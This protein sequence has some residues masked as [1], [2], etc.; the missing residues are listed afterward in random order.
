MRPATVDSLGFK[1]KR[2]IL[3]QLGHLQAH[4]ITHQQLDMFVAFRRGQGVK[5]RTIRD[6]L[7]YIHAV[8]NF[9]V[10]RS[11]IVAN[12]AKGYHPPRD[13]TER[14]R[15]PNKAEFEAIVEKAAPHIQR[16]MWT[17]YFTGARP[18]PIELFSLQW[19]TVD[20]FRG[21]ITI[22]SAQKGGIQLRELNIPDRFM[23]LLRKWWEEDLATEKSTGKKPRFIIHHGG[24]QVKSI[25]TGWDAAKKRAGITRRIRRYDLRH[26]TATELLAAGV[27]IVTIA[28]IL[29]NTVEQCSNAYLH[30]SNDRKKIALDKL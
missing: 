10:Q 2:I 1:F 19:S 11:L 25:R 28:E 21:T 8:L 9:A 27:D 5:N 4:E 6:D 26:M 15:P 13:D 12:Y 29:G 30:V 3:P 16:A 18:G 14:I 22:T 24:G 20:F 23:V 7:T 17:A